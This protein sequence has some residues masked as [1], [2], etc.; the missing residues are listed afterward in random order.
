MADEMTPDPAPVS[1]PQP[2]DAQGQPIPTPDPTSPAT[3]APVAPDAP[4]TPPTP[5]PPTSEQ[6]AA[7]FKKA[8]LQTAADVVGADVPS[9]ATK[10]D[11]ADAIVAAQPTP[12]AAPV[13]MVS[14]AHRRSDEDALFGSWVDVVAGEYSGRFGAF[15]ATVSH[16]TVTGYPDVV[17]IRTRDADNLLV[18]VNYADVR[19]S[20]R[21]GGR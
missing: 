11:I 17:V 5:D 13:T 21:N 14:T 10:A 8:E 18:E 16:D 1:E 6:L 3:G 19:P 20:D 7:D 9:G 15:V 2:V 4:G 12:A